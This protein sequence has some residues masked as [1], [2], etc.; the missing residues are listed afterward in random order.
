MT[1]KWRPVVAVSLSWIL[2]LLSVTAELAHQHGNWPPGNTGVAAVQPND[3]TQLKQTHEYNCVACLFS[4][5]N[6]AADFSY[7]TVSAPQTFCL[8]FVATPHFNHLFC[9]TAS[10]L[11]AP[12]AVL[13]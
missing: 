7:E 1:G 11:R 4:L 10:N 6:I 12:P 9:A 2:L 13:A 5:A 3:A 8:T